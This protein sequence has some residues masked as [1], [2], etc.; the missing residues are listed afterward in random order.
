[1]RR[2]DL[3]AD[4]VRR[5]LALSIVEGACYAVMVGLGEA[6][7]IAD[8][9]RLG[10]APVML[11]LMVGLPL[12]VGGAAAVAGA[13]ALRRVSRRRPLTATLVAIQAAVLVAMAWSAATGRATPGRLLLAVCAY[14]ACGQVCGALWSSWYG[15]L[16]PSTIRGRYFARRARVVHLAT[17]AALI[18]GGFALYGLEG[19]GGPAGAA[20]RGGAGFATLYLAAAAFRLISATLLAL[21]P[22]GRMTDD[23]PAGWRDLRRVTAGDGHGAGPGRILW[24]SAILYSAVY[25]GSPYFSPHM[26]E[27]LHLDYRQFMAASAAQVVAKV[28]SLHAFGRAVDAHGPVAVYRLAAVLIALI[29]LPWLFLSSVPAV[30]AVQAMSGFSWAAHEIGIF[31]LLLSTASARARVLVFAAQSLMNGAAQ[32][33]GSLLGAAVVAFAGSYRAAFLASLVSRGVAAAV[34]SLAVRDLTRPAVSRRRVLLRVIGFRPSG[35]V[36]HRPV[37]EP[38]EPEAEREPEQVQ[39]PELPP[40]IT[41]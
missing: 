3:P 12:A 25:V 10:A 29:P 4:V 15:D 20:A 35:G 18:G 30:L 33:V 9:V 26:L 7:F 37:T 1:M 5:S 38:D 28:V 19:G 40:A 13:T 14:H 17:F 22:E 2:T 24:V 8:A 11:G 23:A 36:A 34:V 32:L 39:E 16:V 31:S 21:S 6:Y 27:G 41:R